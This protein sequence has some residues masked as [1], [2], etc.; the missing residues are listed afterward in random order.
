MRA[1]DAGDGNTTATAVTH[2][3]TAPMRARAPHAM[4]PASRTPNRLLRL[5][6]LVQEETGRLSPEP[7]D[8]RKAIRAGDLT[9]TARLGQCVSTAQS[10]GWRQAPVQPAWPRSAER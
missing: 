8:P 5:R 9:T 3:A 7:F 4:K 10:G 2:A 1:A 6:D